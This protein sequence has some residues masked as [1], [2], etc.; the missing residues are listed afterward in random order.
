MRIT[1]LLEKAENDPTLSETGVLL[2]G[3][4]SV[5]PLACDLFEPDNA[6]SPYRAAL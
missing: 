2:Q 5:P 6:L 4:A 3:P 1:R